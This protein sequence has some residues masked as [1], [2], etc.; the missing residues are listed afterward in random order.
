MGND[1]ADSGALHEPGLFVKAARVGHYR[2]PK[3]FPGHLGKGSL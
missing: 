1:R 3:D 2:L